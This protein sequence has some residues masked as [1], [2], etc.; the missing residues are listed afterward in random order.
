[1]HPNS[2]QSD[3]HGMHICTG[4]KQGRKALFHTVKGSLLK[5]TQCFQNG[6]CFLVQRASS[7]VCH[8]KILRRMSR[9]RND[10]RRLLNSPWTFHLCGT[11]Q[12]GHYSNQLSLS[13]KKK[14]C[15][16]RPKFFFYKNELH[17]SKQI[18]RK[19]TFN[20]K[21]TPRKEKNNF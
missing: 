4:P 2:P 15:Q 11:S 14:K 6:K 5:I 8:E 18:R 19:C 9:Q 12:K 7:S 21:T 3:M 10:P 20:T 17:K 16:K 13:K 1:M